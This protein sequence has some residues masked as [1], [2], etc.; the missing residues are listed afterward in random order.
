MRLTKDEAELLCDVL[1]EHMHEYNLMHSRRPGLFEVLEDLM[2]KIG[3]FGDDKRRKGR[4]SM[5]D[6]SDIHKRLIKRR[7]AK[8]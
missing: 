1:H 8:S 6:L 7:E 5:N 2:N 3:V 4:T